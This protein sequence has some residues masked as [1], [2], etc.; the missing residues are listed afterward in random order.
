MHQY[1]SLPTHF[2]STFV[3]VI[4]VHALNSL[5][6][7]ESVKRFSDA[8]LSFASR[9]AYKP[10]HLRVATTIGHV[11][12]Q[13]AFRFDTSNNRKE[14]LVSFVRQAPTAHQAPRFRRR[15]LARPNLYFRTQVSMCPR[16]YLTMWLT[17]AARALV[18]V[19][20]PRPLLFPLRTLIGQSGSPFFRARGA[21]PRSR[22][23]RE[24]PKTESREKCFAALLT[25]TAAAGTTDRRGR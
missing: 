12:F 1:L 20:E 14:A 7:R 3:H 23:N 21:S 10:I 6:T 9:N 15:S 17:A 2:R 13:T 25:P 16:I 18:C 8:H 5:R 4:H 22:G 24:R 11:Q 19:C